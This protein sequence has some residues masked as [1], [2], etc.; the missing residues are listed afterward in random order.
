MMSPFQS[1]PQ[2]GVPFGPQATGQ[3]FQMG[4][5]AFDTRAQ[6]PVGMMPTVAAPAHMPPVGIVRPLNSP[7]QGNVAPNQ[8]GAA[9][10]SIQDLA[11]Y[12]FFQGGR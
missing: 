10:M 5:N 9:A 7:N 8:G 2:Q 12:L 4:G 11:R 1:P 6:A 3:G